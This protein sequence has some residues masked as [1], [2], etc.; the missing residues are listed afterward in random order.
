MC[1]LEHLG[2]EP[3]DRA[4]RQP[5]QMTRKDRRTSPSPRASRRKQHRGRTSRGSGYDVKKAIAP[6]RNAQSTQALERSR[7]R[8]KSS[9]TSKGTRIQLRWND[10]DD[11]VTDAKAPQ[12]MTSREH[13][14]PKRA[15]VA[16]APARA[17]QCARHSEP[18]ARLPP[19]PR[20]VFTSIR[21]LDIF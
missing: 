18:R 11:T 1:E 13:A 8:F 6:R 7:A 17:G 2:D 4:S 14:L 10:L 15:V 12:P 3:N 16:P 5:E 20:A 21:D 19:C 9:G